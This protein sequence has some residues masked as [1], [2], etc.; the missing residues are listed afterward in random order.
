MSERFDKAAKEWDKNAT[1]T[2]LAENIAAAMIER[3]PFHDE[4]RIMD[5][6]AGTGLLSSGLMSRVGEIYAVDLSTGMLD[7]LDK[8]E[9][10]KGR[11]H[12]HCRNILHDPFQ[13]D[14]DGI[15]SAMALHHVE[16]TAELAKVFFDH[17]KPGGFVALADLDAEDGTFH[18]HGNDGV[19]HFGFD[20]EALGRIFASAGFEDVAFGTAH[21]VEREN[22]RK[23][24]VFLLYAR[25]SKG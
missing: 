16:D 21:T 17:L 2:R 10:L 13:E 24:P 15:V 1:R 9:S 5:F 22:G 6:G 18:R 25:R 4:M 7:E 11:V 8:K 23:Y 19:F 3:V 20:R 12:P 14:F